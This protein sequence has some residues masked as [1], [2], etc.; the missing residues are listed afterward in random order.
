[1]S[2][3]K[4]QV[5]SN[6]KTIG[7]LSPYSYQVRPKTNR[8]PIKVV[9]D[10]VAYQGRLTSGQGKGAVARFY[11]YF[12]Q[13]DFQHWIELTEEAFKELKN[14]QAATLNL[15]TVVAGTGDAPAP[16]ATP[17]P[18]KGKRAPKREQVAAE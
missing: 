10:N 1:M 2:K 14:N 18:A 4:T 8:D 3:I 15:N 12:I 13:G 9:F 6:L 7:T 16:E 17:A 5:T 11:A